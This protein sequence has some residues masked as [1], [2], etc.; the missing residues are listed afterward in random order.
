MMDPEDPQFMALV[1]L[2]GRC[3]AKQFQI[4]YQDDET[5]TVWVAAAIL[6]K[7]ADAAGALDP[8]RAV[9][10]LAEQLIDGGECTHCHR[11]TSV[12][13]DPTGAGLLDVLTCVYRYDP[14]NRTYRRSCEGTN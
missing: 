9:L 12:D 4:R 2:I 13:D 6:P 10:R 14:E 7:G 11:P 5:P 1:D 3:G 8:G